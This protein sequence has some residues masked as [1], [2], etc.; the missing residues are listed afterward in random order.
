MQIMGYTGLFSK[1]IKESHGFELAVLDPS[2]QPCFIHYG[3]FSKN[4]D[5]NER[6]VA[7]YRR[8]GIFRKR[9][10][11]GCSE[12]LASKLDDW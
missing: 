7:L 8:L 6:N 11:F 4:Q 3:A 9:D 10:F 1:S 2:F 12:D 5:I